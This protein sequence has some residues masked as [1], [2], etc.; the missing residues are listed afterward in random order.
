[1]NKK[2]FHHLW[3][4]LRPIKT[5]YFFAA[6]LLF[7]G[8]SVLAL[9]G[10]YLT[11]VDLREKVYQADQSGQNVEQ[12]LQDLRSH[13]NAHMNTSLTSGADSIYPPIHLKE[14]YERLKKAEQDRVNQVNSSVYT[15]AQAHCEQLYPGSFSGGPRVPCIEQFV[16]EH[17]TTA[18]PISD[19]LYKFDFAS[20]TWSPDLAG[21][22]IVL[23]IFFLALAVVRFLLGRLL[24]AM[25]K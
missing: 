2:Y 16:K 7:A 12:A 15:Q 18:K 25:S 21:W 19:A 14:T 13:V 17:G 23:S 20:P 24:E 5:W 8:F 3:A 1:M 9:R 6:F 22:C 4:R 11:M 10:N